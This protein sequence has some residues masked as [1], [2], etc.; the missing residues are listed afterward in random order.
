MEDAAPKEYRPVLIPRRGE[1]IAWILSVLV[2]FVCAVL[3]LTGQKT[4]LLLWILTFILLASALLISLSNWVDRHTVIRIYPDA[5]E[6]HNGLRNVRLFWENILEVRV[7]PGDLGDHVQVYGG[8]AHFT[9]R[10]LGEVHLRGKVQ[11][12]MG[13]ANGG[14]I[15]QQLVTNSGLRM[16]EGTGEEYTYARL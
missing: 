7:Q 14:D 6:F 15:F 5:V 8:D 16:I 10:T 13:F 11:G 2:I 1:V 4:P 12:R 3:I 9:Y